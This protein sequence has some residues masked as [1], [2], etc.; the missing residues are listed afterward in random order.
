MSARV[1]FSG[2]PMFGLDERIVVL[3]Q[4]VRV[5]GQTLTVDTAFE[6][7]YS[8][9]GAR[10]SAVLRVL[11]EGHLL[12]VRQ[13]S[14]RLSVEDG[15]SAEEIRQLLRGLWELRLVTTNRFLPLTAEAA[16]INPSPLPLSPRTAEDLRAM[17]GSAPAPS[18]TIVQTGLTDLSLRRTSV[19]Q[20]DGREV[21]RDH[22][23]SILAVA[24]GV[25]AG[26]RGVPS[27][28]AL[29]PCRVRALLRRGSSYVPVGV[30]SPH[31]AKRVA[32]MF[33]DHVPCADAPAFFVLSADTERATRK[34][35]ARGWRYAV[36]EAGHAAQMILL[37]ALELGLATCELGAFRDESVARILRFSPRELPLVVIACGHA[38]PV[39]ESAD[40]PSVMSAY[41]GPTGIVPH[42]KVRRRP[43][44]LFPEPFY[45]EAEVSL[46]VAQRGRGFNVQRAGSDAADAET[47]AIKAVAEGVERF[48]TGWIPSPAFVGTIHGK[49]D[50]QFL[51]PAAFQAFGS[52]Q[53]FPKDLSR[54]H[55]RST[56]SWFPVTRW[57]TRDVSLIPGDFLFYP[58]G[59]LG[60]KAYSQAT[61]NGVAAHPR[62]K[63]A[64]WRATAELLERENL[65]VWWFSGCRPPA[66]GAEGKHLE[67]IRRAWSKKG[68]DL[69]FLNVTL[70]VP[71]V[72]AVALVRGRP[73][74]YVASAAA[75]SLQEAASK[76]CS[77]VLR[78]VEGNADDHRQLRP[79]RVRD[80]A[81][82]LR[83]FAGGYGYRYLA[84]W[85]MG[86][87]PMTVG[88]SIFGST[89]D[90]RLQKV[91]D[92]V[93]TVYYHKFRLPKRVFPSQPLA[94]VRVLIPEVTS[95]RFGYGAQD[96][97]LK[98]FQELLGR[99]R[100]SF[101]RVPLEIPVIHPLA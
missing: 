84:E 75:A 61:S 90:D 39:A 57:G 87:T 97:G 29:Y 76:A 45:A 49:A 86:G 31:A 63:E 43:S 10:V 2:G 42:V 40:R 12:T 8:I 92:T 62:Q 7:D 85:S 27:A 41:V 60:G 79:E 18:S 46:P 88:D 28:G 95:I 25:R 58:Y 51:D 66:I 82:H 69:R 55:G 77:E 11:R 34:Y 24:Y 72:A 33:I 67:P 17:G 26:H 9:K 36:L 98:R 22:A 68:I 78:S 3:A 52:N 32:S 15:L 91:V 81:D 83:C 53:A 54:F 50:T 47:A 74:A 38:A 35:G 80:V 71:T 16:G 20:F 1:L 70:S 99:L 65:L 21:A 4:R 37:H 19:R 56:A 6:R 5:R 23:E 96:M 13:L 14:R 30:G 101:E 73:A 59:E 94:V 48:A 89:D 44:R 64:L 93:G 100:R